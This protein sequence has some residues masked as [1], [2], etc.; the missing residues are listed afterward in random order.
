MPPGESLAAYAAT[1]ATLV[2]HLAVQRIA[3]LVPELVAHYGAD[4]PAAV[5]AYASRDDELILRGTL[6]DIAAQVER[7]GVRRTAVVIVGPVLTAA[8]FPDSHLYSTTR[9]R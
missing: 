9:S 1:G 8:E 5:V 3:E 7:V 6:A 4:C 2:L